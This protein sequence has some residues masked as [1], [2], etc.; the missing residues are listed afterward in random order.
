MPVLTVSAARDLIHSAL[1][2]SGLAQSHAPY[3]TEAIL[4]TCPSS[5]DLEQPR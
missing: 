1:T 3:F 2:G 5:N 4:D